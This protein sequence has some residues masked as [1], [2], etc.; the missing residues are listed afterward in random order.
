MAEINYFTC[1]LGQAALL[2]KQRG[3]N[4][5]NE[6]ID[7]Q[8]ARVPD[9]PAVGFYTPNIEDGKA[10]TSH[11]LNFRDIR[12]G[13]CVVAEIISGRFLLQ[14]RQTVALLGPSTAEFLFL[15]LALMR[16]GHP[17]L[18]LAPQ[19]SPSAITYLCGTC[20]VE[21]LFYDIMYEDLADESS[22]EPSIP[23][24]TR[25][26]CHAIQSL[27]SMDIYEATQQQPRGR[28][29]TQD[30][31][32][33]DIAYL[34]HT[35]G[36][37]SGMPRPIPQTH[38]A[39][40]GVLPT[41]DGKE[42][43]TFTTTPLYHGGI[44][45][46]FRAWTSDAMI[47]LFPEKGV[48]ITPKS[49]VRCLDIAKGNHDTK[50]TPPVAYFSSVPYVLQMMAGNESGLQMLQAMKIVGVG[51][52]ALPMDIGDRL[53][54]QKLNLISRFGSA[55]CGFLLTS[56]RHYANDKEWQ[57]LRQD[58]NV[59]TLRFEAQEGGLS[60][61]VVLSSW[62]HLAQK[63]RE[64]G[65]FATA[66]LFE[67]HP[68]IK[69]AWRYHSRADS[70]LTLI[71]G[72]KFD[73]ASL[74]AA[75]ATSYL[76][77]DVLI[78]GDGKPYPGVLLFRSLAAKESSD[79]ELIS[80]L[81]P[82][83][84]KMNVE[85]QK[86]IRL[87]R[88]ML[89]PMPYLAEALQKSSKGTILR[90][91]AEKQYASEIEQAYNQVFLGNGKNIEDSEVP[92][93][94][95]KVIVSV[96][97]REENLT[98]ETDLFS[99]GVDSVACVQIRH[100][101]IPLLPESS[102]DLSL[103]IVEECGTISKLVNYIISRRHGNDCVEDDQ[104]Q[105]MLGLVE[106]YSDFSDHLRENGHT[107]SILDTKS[108]NKPSKEVILLTGATGALGAHILNLYLNSTKIA[109]IYL[110]VRGASDHAAA[111][112]VSKALSSRKLTLLSSFS[113][114]R[115]TVLSSS[116]SHPTLGLPDSTYDSLAKTVT[117]IHHVSWAVNFRL[118]LSSFSQHI[119]GLQNLIS[120][121]L[122]AP[123]NP[124]KFIFC[125]SVA[126]VSKSPPS[127]PVSECIS[128]DTTH[129]GPLGYSRSKWVAEAVC[130]A[131]DQ[132]TRLRGRISVM[133]VGQLSGDT[134][135]GIWN[136]GEAYPMLLSQVSL[137]KTLPKLQ[138]ELSWLPVDTAARA[139]IEV[140][141][142]MNT[143][144]ETQE[145]QVFH[146]VNTDQTT[147][148]AD[149]MRWVKKAMP[150]LNI[151]EP[152]HFVEKLETLQKE[153]KDHPAMR[154]LP[155][156][157]AAYAMEKD[158]NERESKQNGALTFQTT[159]TYAVAPILRTVKPVNEAYFEKIWKWIQDQNLSTTSS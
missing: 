105:L 143:M 1:T 90:K 32:E 5:I 94:I 88:N 37:A 106:K 56:H 52:A 92:S 42:E 154:L 86:H 55:E 83:I 7:E 36:T 81:D 35:S 76:L 6:F 108:I 19:C 109:H 72:K 70:Q 147:Q 156:W 144:N 41:L 48:P 135:N 4:C 71:T 28:V 75:I 150:D 110:L 59:N 148:W 49:I 9:L 31:S 40:I 155:H 29:P 57:F 100:A 20:H 96:I 21:R 116:L 11:V 142:A 85:S 152:Q 117:T 126:S 104:E 43:A 69:N 17:V 157:K 73:P 8:A 44:A 62:P 54:R 25:L 22:Q 16:L 125:S 111:E 141:K 124:P 82:M 51:G 65:T 80:A 68:T 24:K 63:N 151:V 114:G 129:A 10:W 101:V 97:G 122:C 46:L 14:K 137:T 3:Y 112:R 89:V 93:T 67:S 13:S 30:I 78:F 64:D 132:K 39:G 102:R 95:R 119:A 15:W 145:M 134:A 146:I 77:R 18:L 45:D 87:A 158:P 50:G 58:E 38:R 99:Y 113:D 23:R 107:P 53:V 128:S 115:V 98:N 27:L 84:G 131:A 123:Q 12:R 33:H 118:S 26:E 159:K 130:N 140:A 47:W 127:N 66:D 74:E 120:L 133:R 139:F 138:D 79:E 61:L 91:V 153:G 60:E 136:M 149:L 34:H 121:A 103:T 2:Q